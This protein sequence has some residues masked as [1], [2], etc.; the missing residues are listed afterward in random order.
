MKET[1][2]KRRTLNQQIFLVVF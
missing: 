2:K 1:T